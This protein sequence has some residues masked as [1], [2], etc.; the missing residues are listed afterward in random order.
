M[1]GRGADLKCVVKGNAVRNGDDEFDS[2]VEALEDGVFGEAGWNEEHRGV[3]VSA[4][5]KGATH[6][7]VDGNI[8][9]AA[10]L[11]CRA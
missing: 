3:C 2:C 1:R 6:S 5:V 11:L 10:L 9:D 8:A 4:R 7:V